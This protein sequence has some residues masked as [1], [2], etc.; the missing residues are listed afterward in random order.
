MSKIS[1]ASL[2]LK[3]KDEP[4]VLDNGIEVSSYAS[5]NDKYDIINTALAKS[6]HSEIEGMYDRT[7]LKVFF[8]LGVVYIYTNITFTD[9]Q[10]EDEV[11]IYDCLKSN[12]ILQEVLDSI[13]DFDELQDMLWE[14][15]AVR[16]NAAMQTGYLIKQFVKNLPLTAK[17]MSEVIDNFDP[18][19]YEQVKNYAEAIGARFDKQGNLE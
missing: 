8:E 12:G 14:E 15:V 3:V 10:R 18:D 4:I 16:E 6:T 13:E 11:K 7:L 19:K 2:K 5:I 9:K 1:F 17:E